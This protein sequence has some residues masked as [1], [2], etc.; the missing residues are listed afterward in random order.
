MLKTEGCLTNAS[1]LRDGE[2]SCDSVGQLF[3]VLTNLINKYFL[4]QLHLNKLE[5]NT[6]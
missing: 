2:I 3:E 4:R 1:I 5:K 6:Y